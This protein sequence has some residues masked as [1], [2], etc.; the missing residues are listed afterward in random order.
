M[1]MHRHNQRGLSLISLMIALLIGSF[2]L[3]GLFDVWF[4]TRTTF[5]TQ[6]QMSQV[7]DNQRMALIVLANAVQTAGYYPLSAN[8]GTN[9][10]TPLYTQQNV[11]NASSPFT[12][13]GQ[14]V[15]GTHSSTT[16]TNDTLQVRFMADTAANAGNTLDCMGQVDTAQ[17]VVTETFAITNSNLTCQLSTQTSPATII[18]GV[19]GLE[20][21]YGVATNHDNS[22]TEYLTADQVTSHAM[23]AYVQSVNLQLTFVNPLYGQSGVPG[24]TS[25]TLL[26]ISRIVLLTQNAK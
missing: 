26:P 8:Y 1:N 3:A 25:A 2:L 10:P 11:F 21:F 9:P 14:A 19:E 13:A 4:Q 7:Q 23:W 24:Q 22:V 20:V 18:S 12:V 15:Y 17:T 5:K 6:N 16:P